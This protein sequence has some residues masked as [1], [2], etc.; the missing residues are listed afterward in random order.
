MISSFHQSKGLERKIVVVFNFDQSYFKYYAKH[1]NTDVVP[2]TLYV[3]CTR[4][5]DILILVGIYILIL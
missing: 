1:E 2:N 4:A 5:K 3:A